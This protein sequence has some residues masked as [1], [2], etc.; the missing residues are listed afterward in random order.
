MAREVRLSLGRPGSSKS[1]GAPQCRCGVSS[2]TPE[3]SRHSGIHDAIPAAEKLQ[4]ECLGCRWWT[5]WIANI[6]EAVHKSAELQVYF[7]HKMKGKGKVE[8]FATAG[9]EHLRR[10]QILAKKRDFI[11]GSEE[12]RRARS[13]G[14]EELCKKN[15]RD[16]SSQY[17]REEHRLFLAWLDKAD[18]EFLN[19]SVSCLSPHEG[20]GPL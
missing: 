19:A 15:C 6:E 4:G 13:E 10:E 3:G 17:S 2:L 7:F 5:H 16:A 14:L 1:H 9:E 12:F 11:K 18:R 20:L 8:T